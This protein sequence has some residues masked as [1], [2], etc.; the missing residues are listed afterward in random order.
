MVRTLVR[1]GALVAV[2]VILLFTHGIAAHLTPW[3]QAIINGIVKY[4]YPP[5]GQRETTVVLFLEQNLRDLG[6]SYPVSYERHAEVLEAMSL[7]KPRAVFMDFVF[8]DARSREEVVLLRDAICHLAS[9]E[10]TVYVAVL[11]PQTPPPAPEHGL[12]K[13]AV[14]VSAQMEAGEGA[15]GVLR[16]VHGVDFG[17]AGFLSTPA[18]AMA[19]TH[20]EIE[21][22]QRQKMELIWGNQVPKLN[23]SWMKGCDREGSWWAHLRSV[24]S[25]DPF[26]EAKLQCPYTQTITVGHLLGSSSD[27][28]VGK[29]LADSTVFY[30]AAFHLTGDRVASPT[31]ADLPAVYLHAMAYD[32]LR[33]LQNDYKRADRKL[34]LLSLSAGHIVLPLTWV[35]DVMLLLVTVGILLLVEEPPPALQ[36]LRGRFVRTRTWVKW[37]ILGLGV[38]PLGVA[39]AADRWLWV[40]GLGLPVLMGA[41]AFL[42]LTPPA[43]RPPHT[44]QEFVARRLL[45]LAVPILAVLIFIAVDRGVG[46][47]AAL[48]LVALPAYFLYRVAVARDMLFAATSVLLVLASVVIVLPPVNLGPRNVMAYVAFFEVARHLLKHADHVGA[49]YADLRAKHPRDRE[50]GWAEPFMPALDWVFAV[51]RR[52]SIRPAI[53]TEIKE[54]TH[55]KTAGAPA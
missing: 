18:F 38:L 42:D 6:E 14:Q 47:E 33:T 25:K 48:L 15:S 11:A 23:R 2:G 53:K 37:L 40:A 39:V 24:F 41:I 20:P 44:L 22:R 8:I 13:C 43:E 4:T 51:C 32:N 55:G 36:R 52:E 26:K 1:L 34:V 19:D 9:G 10:T 27:A 45:A 3:S 49:Q 50:W 46:L 5:V 54:E 7:H 29:A 28:D 21:L 30:G 35:V 17:P 16:Y 31:F 12:L